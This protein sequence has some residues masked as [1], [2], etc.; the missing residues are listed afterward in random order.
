MIQWDKD[1][2]D[3]LGLLKVDVLALGML[4]AIRRAF[5]LVNQFG[6]FGGP[7]PGELDMARRPPSEG[8]RRV[9]HDLPRP[10][11]TGGVPNR[12]AGRRCPCCLA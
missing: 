9:R 1:D 11:T 10:K 3:V 6:R 5:G 7:C 8:Q 12:I 2:L 4:S